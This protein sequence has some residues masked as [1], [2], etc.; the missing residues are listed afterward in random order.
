MIENIKN[1]SKKIG[2]IQPSMNPHTVDSEWLE[3]DYLLKNK[4]D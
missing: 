4:I 3:L 1:E 2:T